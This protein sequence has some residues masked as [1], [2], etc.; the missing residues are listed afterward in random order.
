MIF[1]QLYALSEVRGVSRKRIFGAFKTFRIQFF[2]NAKISLKL[3]NYAS[4]IFS[5]SVLIRSLSYDGQKV[6][7]VLTDCFLELEERRKHMA[8]VGV[9]P[10]TFALLAR[11]SNQLS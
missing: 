1:L 9:E 4:I 7:H 8:S 11:R 2:P 10:T 6:T 5:K 3:D